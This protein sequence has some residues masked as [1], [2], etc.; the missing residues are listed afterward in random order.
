MD[1]ALAAVIVAG[2]TLGFNVLL[3]MFGGGW[4][5]SKRLTAL[6]AGIAAM[7]AEIKK[8]SDVL[9]KMADMRGELRVHDTRI[10]AAEQ[11][12]RELRHGE[13]FIRGTRGVEKE[14]P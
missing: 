1:T 12:I 4:S 14:Y 3:Q 5:L 9:I 6:E 7:Q 2:V 10:T 8:L 11:D 13:G